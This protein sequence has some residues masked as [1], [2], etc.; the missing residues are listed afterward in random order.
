MPEQYG[1]EAKSRAASLH[2]YGGYSYG[3]LTKV[4]ALPN[5]K[6]T[7]STWAE[8]GYGTNGTP[9]SEIKSLVK[10]EAEVAA[11]QKEIEQDLGTMNDVADRA[12]PLLVEA[13]EHLR[14]QL[15]REGDANPTWSK[16]SDLVEK[17]GQFARQQH[18]TEIQER[19]KKLAEEVGSI[20]GREISDDTTAR[21]VQAEVQE[22]FNEAYKDIDTLIGID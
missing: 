12:G 1:E 10:K 14:D 6:G 5:S 11:E 3:D 22:V 4:D 13:A 20:L 18:V 8:K 19:L 9:W 17:I 16:Y 15:I 2:I 21:R 7:F